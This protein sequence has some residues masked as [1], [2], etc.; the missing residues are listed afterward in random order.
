MTAFKAKRA[1]RTH[2]HTVTT[3]LLS[4][5]QYV[6]LLVLVR[7]GLGVGRGLLEGQVSPPLSLQVSNVTLNHSNPPTAPTHHN[8]DETTPKA[9]DKHQGSP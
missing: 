6:R 1:S 8:D 3:L 9:D 4:L 2:A 5:K 7:R